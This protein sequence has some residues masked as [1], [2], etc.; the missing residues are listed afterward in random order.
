M[1]YYAEKTSMD[2][3]KLGMP[4][5]GG[6]CITALWLGVAFSLFAF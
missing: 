2:M 6:L 1:S 3:G 5:I 4:V